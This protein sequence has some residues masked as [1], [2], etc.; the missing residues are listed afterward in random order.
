MIRR[1]APLALLAGTLLAPLALPAQ[2]AAPNNRPSTI[3][4]A[5]PF[6][7][8]LGYFQGEF[9]KRVKDNLAMA[10]GF[11]HVR[12]DGRYT[13]A[14]LKARLYPQ[15]KAPYGLGLAAGIGVGY[16]SDKQYVEVSCAAIG[17]IPP[18]S[19]QTFT[20]TAP[21]FS[22]E[23]HYQWLLGRKQSTAVGFGFGAKRYFIAN[24]TNEYG[25]DRF[26]EFVPTGRITVGW[27]FGKR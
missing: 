23:L 16:L 22:V 4:S 27:A 19:E 17:C 11:S 3:L 10:F 9:E 24:N 2:E 20:R 8:L 25:S 26:Q 18:G 12:M 15:E 14:D 5:N 7:P 21:S 6:L 13:N 1:L